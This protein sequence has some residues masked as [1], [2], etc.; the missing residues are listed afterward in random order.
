VGFVAPGVTRC[1]LTASATAAVGLNV[2]TVCVNAGKFPVHDMAVLDRDDASLVPVHMSAGA[3]PLKFDGGSQRVLAMDLTDK[4][5]TPH[6]S[7]V[8][9]DAADPLYDSQRSS[10]R[11]RTPTQRLAES[12]LKDS[13]RLIFLSGG[14]RDHGSASTASQDEAGGSRRGRR[15]R[16]ADGQGARGEQ[17]VGRSSQAAGVRPEKRRRG[18]EGAGSRPKRAAAAMMGEV[19]REICM[20]KLYVRRAGKGGSSGKLSSMR[21][22]RS[23]S[24]DAAG[25]RRQDRQA[26]QSEGSER[27][28]RGSGERGGKVQNGRLRK[29]PVVKAGSGSKTRLDLGSN[30]ASSNGASAG[31]ASVPGKSAVG[32]DDA[33]DA[34]TGSSEQGTHRR[35][36][37]LMEVDAVGRNRPPFARTMLYHGT[38]PFPLPADLSDQAAAR[39]WVIKRWP[40]KTNRR[41]IDQEVHECIKAHPH[42]YLVRI[43]DVSPSEGVLME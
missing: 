19:K 42:P 15:Q 26:S 3:K 37:G 1:V 5:A 39:N 12:N 2:Q 38:V 6:T 32:G 25:G 20:E 10:G 17:G 7:S 29:L 23:G 4:A 36:W 28:V 27:R 40:E 8:E 43:V 41:K 24:G 18:D 34:S 22:R 35:D 30:A 16:S 14:G 9:M 11:S 31:K 33:D 13:T 21:P